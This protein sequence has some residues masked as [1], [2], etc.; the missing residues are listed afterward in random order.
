MLSVFEPL[1]SKWR[2]MGY[3]LFVQ[4]VLA[5]VHLSNLKQFTHI[6]LFTSDIH[7]SVYETELWLSILLRW[8]ILTIGLLISLQIYFFLFLKLFLLLMLNYTV[9]LRTMIWTFLYLCRFKHHLQCSHNH[10]DSEQQNMIKLKK[11]EA[12]MK[13]ISL[14]KKPFLPIKPPVAW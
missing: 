10:Y 14:N 8:V 13:C 9:I 11:N 6:F 1:G 2:Q 12:F 5:N 4:N 3:S 7:K